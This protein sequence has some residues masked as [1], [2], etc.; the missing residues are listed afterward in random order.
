MHL[1]EG[2]V[3]ILLGIGLY[4]WAYSMNHSA[5]APQWAR[6]QLFASAA[7]L[8]LVCIAPLGAG[9]VTLG[10]GEPLT[11]AGW[12]GLAGLALAPLGL[13]RVLRG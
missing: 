2:V 9:L 6:G 5:T 7:T 3:A 11:T 13:W 4:G 10:L 12:I 8:A 1:L